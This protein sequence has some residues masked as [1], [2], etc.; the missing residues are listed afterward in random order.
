I[1]AIRA[2]LAAAQHD[3][4]TCIAQSRRALEYLRP[5]NLPVR[6]ATT[7][8]L[9]W[10]YQV[11]G[12]RAAAGR[13]YRE[14]V[15]I[16]QASGN[17][18]IYLAASAGLGSVQEG[19]N[20]L[21]AAAQTYRRI[22]ELAGDPP[23]PVACDAHLGLARLGY[24][25]NDLDVAHQHAQQSIYLAR[26]VDAA[27]RIVAAEVMLARLKL[28]QGDA[29]GAAA[30]LGE[31][32]EAARQRNAA[33]RMTEVVTAQVMTWL[34]RGNLAA[35]AQLAQAHDLPLCQARVHLARG[36]SVA[37]LAVLEP[38]R[39][40]VENAGWEDER[41]KV[42]LLQAVALQARGEQDKAVQVVGA[43]LALAEPEGFIRS[44][45]DEGAPM[46]HLVS[47]VLARGVMPDYAAKLV[48]AF[49]AEP[50][51]RADRSDR[52]PDQPLIEP[53]SQRELE[54]LQLIAQGLSNQEISERLVLALD[55]VKGHN[56]KIFGKLQVQRRTEAVAK[57]RSLHLLPAQ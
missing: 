54:V 6:T 24:E 26:Q 33:H 4:E 11:Q 23:N 29:A 18:I 41:L 51:L 32:S 48:A 17:T 36:D 3:V 31:A 13:A 43:A 44:V 28:A 53:L 35:A 21:H 56:R 42:L 47:D 49:D 14:A 45:V 46:A 39:R 57:A 10:A 52:R 16:S 5:D 19:Q 15:S 1:A 27:D 40:R 12:D 20:Q 50:K 34:R 25:W 9:G 7:W 30:L 55:T 38:W 37:A 22:L 2:V 8:K